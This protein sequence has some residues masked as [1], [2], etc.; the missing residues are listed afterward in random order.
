M[1]IW[2]KIRGVQAQSSS[3]QPA[4]AYQAACATM[5]AALPPDLRRFDSVAHARQ[6]LEDEI[7]RQ[8]A[9]AQAK[10]ANSGYWGNVGQLVLQAAAMAANIAQHPVTDDPNAYV[11][12]CNT[13]LLELT[14]EFRADPDDED[15]Y[16]VATVHEIR[17]ILQC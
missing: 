11:V 10:L 4:P 9:D 7:A 3:E 8:M 13:E 14:A 1:K 15:G 17:R 5:P 2:Q 12:A 16:G 6:A